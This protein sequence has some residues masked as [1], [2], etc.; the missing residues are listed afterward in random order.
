MSYRKTLFWVSF[1]SIAMGFLESAVVIYL[2]KLYYPHGFTFPL[3]PMPNDISVV[4]IWREAATIIMLLSIGIIA[5]RNRVERFAWFIFS[6][7]VW[8]IFYYIFLFV[9]L[10]WPQSLMTWD[11]LFLIP[12]PWVGP[13]VTPVIIAVT[14]ILF[15]VSVIYYSRKGLAAY[16]R[17][18][19]T[20][21]L[22]LGSL[23]AIVAF[24]QDYVFQK[25]DILYRNIRMGGSLFTDLANYVPLHFDW[26]VFWAGEAI[27]LLAWFFY[28]KRMKQA[29]KP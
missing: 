27:I 2:R 18:K 13:V 25:G 12:V 17:W 22:I 29:G 19:E 11:I 8:D 6:F 4:E 9:F 3:T 15:A 26:P 23:I 14:M 28:T 16:L 20:S 5:G 21:L 24:T 1:F 7:A 10:G